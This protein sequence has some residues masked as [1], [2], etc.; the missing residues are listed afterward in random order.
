MSQPTTTEKNLDPAQNLGQYQHE[1][2]NTS[3]EPAYPWD[4]NNNNWSTYLHQFDTY[5]DRAVQA[6]CIYPRAM[7]WPWG[8]AILDIDRTTIHLGGRGMPMESCNQVCRDILKDNTN[9]KMFAECLY[10][11]HGKTCIADFSSVSQIIPSY[12]KEEPSVTS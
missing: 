11:K 10:S 12:T 1:Y 2:S 6:Q 4:N 7:D 3:H 9:D 8:Q 5:L